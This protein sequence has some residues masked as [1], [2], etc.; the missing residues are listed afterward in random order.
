MET[1]IGS[2]PLGSQ[3]EE[4]KDNVKYLCPWY[5]QVRG[6]NPQSEEEINE[7]RCAIAWMPLLQI[8]TS[9]QSRQTGAAVESFRNNINEQNND[10]IK[11][12]EQKLISGGR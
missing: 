11:L 7:W 9:Q 6:K 12:S 5:V 1:R 8:E 3:C 10:L 2:C 4:I